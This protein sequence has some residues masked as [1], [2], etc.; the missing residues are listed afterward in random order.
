[1]VEL[2][3]VGG[4][5]WLGSVLTDQPNSMG[6]NKAVQVTGFSPQ[7]INGDLLTHA[8]FKQ[9][10]IEGQAEGAIGIVSGPVATAL[11]N[12]PLQIAA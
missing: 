11:L 10:G 6:Q 1:M 5:S 3:V 7:N 4:T 8:T 9:N 2:Q 12:S